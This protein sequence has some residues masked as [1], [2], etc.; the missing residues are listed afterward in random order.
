MTIFIFTDGGSRGNPGPAA[1]GVT[2]HDES[3]N[4][5]F[6]VG[7][8]LGITTNNEAE[9]QAFLAA[10]EWLNSALQTDQFAGKVEKIVF[11]LDSKLVVEQLLKNWKIKEPRMAQ[12]AQKC[13]A[14]LHTLTIPYSIQHVPREQ[15]RRAD[16][17]VNQ[18]LD[19]V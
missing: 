7:T 17:L 4:V 15:N 18:A 3:E 6:E 14:I 11:S 12:W 9:Y 19:A 13:W 5:L 8:P 2:A 1:L 16:A 10:C